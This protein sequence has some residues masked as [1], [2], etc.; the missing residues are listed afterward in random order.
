M[1]QVVARD[2]SDDD[3]RVV[4]AAALIR[5][6]D[7]S[8]A[9]CLLVGTFGQYTQHLVVTELARYAI[10]AEK[11]HVTPS[12]RDPSESN[13]HA[14]AL[15]HGLHDDAFVRRF[16][17]LFPRHDACINERLDVALVFRD[18]ADA[19]KAN[20][21]HARIAHTR[22]VRELGVHN[23]CHQRC[24]HSLFARVVRRTPHVEVR[25]FDR[26]ANGLEDLALLAVAS[27]VLTERLDDQSARD[28]AS[29]RA[30]HSV[31]DREEHPAI[32][33][34]V[35]SDRVRGARLGARQVRDEERVF[36]RLADLAYVC[37]PECAY[38]GRCD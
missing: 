4:L 16:L 7:K 17:S 14:V 35:G 19:A 13:I 8:L 33:D 9:R 1:R 23:D 5:K 15:S 27:K 36:V 11:K 2:L 29:L 21:V 10:R 26:A 12:D 28:G 25:L 34:R 20:E 6:L 22:D 24:A 37:S 32:P 38:D 18:L 30:A 3:S 31:G